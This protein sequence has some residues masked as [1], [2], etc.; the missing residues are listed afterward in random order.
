MS[1]M[2]INKEHKEVYEMLK[3]CGEENIVIVDDNLILLA[4]N[5]YD[6]KLSMKTSNRST[7]KLKGYTAMEDG[8]FLVYNKDGLMF[9][10]PVNMVALLQNEDGYTTGYMFRLLDIETKPDELGFKTNGILVYTYLEEIEATE[11]ADMDN[12]Y[13]VGNNVDDETLQNSLVDVS[14]DI[15]LNNIGSDYIFTFNK[16][17]YRY[18][19]SVMTL[20]CMN[21]KFRNIGKLIKRD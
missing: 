15:Q 9:S 8:I 13:F 3:E 6:K 11:K 17:K 4:L 1:L 20:N 16:E 19:N 7:I 2:K 18:S 12:M 14:D 21:R 5:S 10:E